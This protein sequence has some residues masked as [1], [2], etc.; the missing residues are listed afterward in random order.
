M[1]VSVILA[2][3]PPIRKFIGAS[4]ANPAS[5]KKKNY[6]DP[7]NYASTYDALAEFAK[8]IPQHQINLQ[9]IIGSGE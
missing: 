9:T 8:E 1:H 2:S 6:V 3:T 4:A 5:G 7:R